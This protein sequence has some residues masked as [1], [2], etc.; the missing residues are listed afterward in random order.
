MEGR[1]TVDVFEGSL[2]GAGPGSR[3]SSVSPPRLGAFSIGASARETWVGARL[4]ASMNLL[5]A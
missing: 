3:R 2:H 4:A 5:S 1:I